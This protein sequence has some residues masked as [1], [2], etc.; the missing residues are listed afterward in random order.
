MT[1]PRLSFAVVST[2]R[3]LRRQ[4]DKLTSIASAT[5]ISLG[6][7]HKA[8]RDIACPVN[9]SSMFRRRATSLESLR[10]ARQDLRDDTAQNHHSKQLLPCP[11][12]TRMEL[13]Y[14]Q[15]EFAESQGV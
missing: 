11:Q 6:A 2:A 1:R 5:G 13:K 14:A 7:A 9:H 8:V 10:Q 15:N 4:G 3:R 12:Q